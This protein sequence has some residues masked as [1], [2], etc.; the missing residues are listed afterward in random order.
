V[1]ALSFASDKRHQ[2][3]TVLF[4]DSV[5][6]WRDPGVLPRDLDPDPP[7]TA[8]EDGKPMDIKD[9]LAIP[10]PRVIRL[11]NGTDLNVKWCDTCGTYRPPRSSHCRVCDNCVENIGECVS[12]REVIVD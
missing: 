8:G 7:C 9:R 2:I 12:K 1:S 5:T 6:A 11:R 4:F 3:L 10:L